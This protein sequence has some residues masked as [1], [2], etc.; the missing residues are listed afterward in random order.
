MAAAAATNAQAATMDG[1]TT[2]PAPVGMDHGRART[3]Q[4]EFQNMFVEFLTDFRDTD[5]EGMEQAVDGEEEDAFMFKYRRM[6]LEDLEF[7]RTGMLTV[8]FRDINNF[9]MQLET[10]LRTQFYEVEPTLRAAVTQLVRRVRPDLIA[11]G[12]GEE[13]L[14][15]GVRFVDLPECERLRD[16]KVDKIGH[17]TSFAGTVT[18]TSEGG[19]KSKALHITHACNAT[20]MLHA[21]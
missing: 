13:Q 12:P 3:V 18:R 16:L 17:L 8:S 9:S 19:H 5:A 2:V 20:C 7:D 10:A 21:R 4:N 11:E 1:A 6:V 15:F 14:E